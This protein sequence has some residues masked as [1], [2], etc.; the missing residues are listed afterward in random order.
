[1]ALQSSSHSSESSHG[2]EAIDTAVA[3]FSLG[4]MSVEDSTYIRRAASTPQGL[5]SLAA[6]AGVAVEELR[7]I[8]DAS[9]RFLPSAYLDTHEVTLKKLCLAHRRASGQVSF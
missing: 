1:M 4:T 2:S 3:S 7:C 9:G 8:M 6:E 5:E